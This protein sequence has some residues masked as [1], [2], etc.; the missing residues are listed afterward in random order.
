VHSDGIRHRVKVPVF[1]LEDSDATHRMKKDEVRTPAVG[2][3]LDTNLSTFW[4]EL[5]KEVEHAVFAK[6]VFTQSGAR[7]G[8]ALTRPQRFTLTSSR[9]QG[10]AIRIP[11]AC[12]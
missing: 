1:D 8:W 11:P 12:L 2:V 4:E 10:E 3:R 7:L 6:G 5:V 9:G